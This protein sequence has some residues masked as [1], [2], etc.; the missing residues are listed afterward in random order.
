MKFDKLYNFRDVGG[1]PTHDGR[2]MRTGVVYRS[3]D[4]SR[5]SA[6]DMATLRELDIKLICDLR[7]PAQSKKTRD[8]SIPVVNIPLHEQMTEEEG[9]KKVLGF[10]FAK[11]GDARFRDFSRWYYDHIAFEQTA[12]VRE[13]IT[14]LANEPV[15]M[16]IHCKAG[17]DRTG[18]VAAVIQ[19]LAGVP[20]EAVLADYLRTNDAYAPRRERIVRTARW[21]TFFRVSPER[22]RLLLSAHGEFL[23]GVHTKIV[24]QHG[25][26][27]RY[28]CD[29]CGIDTSTL[30]RLKGRLL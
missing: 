25:T 3:D 2:V 14:L 29:A 17:K 8:L 19:L 12:R 1:Q 11:G 5:I 28:L 18:F 27:E 13:V 4:A 7:T 10:L 22:M 21:L 6:R 20:Y 24:D 26:I 16:L 15:P 30:E 23:D 9:R